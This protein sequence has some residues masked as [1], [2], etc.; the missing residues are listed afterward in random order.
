VHVAD[1]IDVLHCQKVYARQ[2]PRVLTEEM[3]ASRVKLCWQLLSCY[4]NEDEEF[5]HN[6]VTAHET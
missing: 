5:L 4:E 3:K 2:V 6:T 1:I